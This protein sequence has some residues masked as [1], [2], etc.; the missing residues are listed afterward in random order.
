V[1][2]LRD[3]GVRDIVVYSPSGRAERFA[4]RLGLAFTTDLVSGLADSAVVVTCTSRPEPVVTPAL[5]SPGSRRLIVDLGLPRNV[6]PG[7]AHVDGVELLHLETIR[8]HA[9]LGELTATSD[10]PEIVL[11]AAAEFH[12]RESE[13]LAGP[14]IAAMRRQA[15]AVLE[16]EIDRS[17]RR[18]SWSEEGESGMRHLLGVLLHAPSE[19]ARLAAREGD[20]DAVFDA[21]ST[22]FGPVDELGRRRVADEHLDDEQGAVR[23]VTA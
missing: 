2:A 20:V 23:D 12:A 22:L 17:K 21:V 7:V 16:S 14:A 10:A 19:R 4:A 15:F 18:G 5:L 9:P 13:R 11:D 1:A 6:G 3:R 8:L